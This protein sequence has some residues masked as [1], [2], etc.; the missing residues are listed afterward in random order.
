MAK[1]PNPAVRE[2]IIE[3]VRNQVRDGTPPETGKTLDR[4]VAD[5]HT[6]EQ[7]EELIAC[8]VCSEMSDM[9]KNSEVFNETRYLAALRRLPK[10]P[11]EDV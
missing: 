2:A 10:L 1:V 5:G 4:L 11:W 3:I 6:R 9:L 8:V 7:A